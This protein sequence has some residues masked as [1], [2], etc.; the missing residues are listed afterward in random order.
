M[1]LSDQQHAVAGGVFVVLDYYKHYPSVTRIAVEDT[2]REI[3]AQLSRQDHNFD[4][5]QFLVACGVSYA[6]HN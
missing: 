6:K 1:S 2:A 4:R 5:D 3:A